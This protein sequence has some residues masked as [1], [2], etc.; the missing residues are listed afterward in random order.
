MW[1]ISEHIDRACARGRSET[2]KRGS[3]LWEAI[4]RACRP[5]GRLMCVPV[6]LGMALAKPAA[7]SFV[8]GYAPVDFTL[9]NV[10]ADGTAA[11]GDGGVSLS[12]TGGNNGSDAPGTTDVTIAALG[13]GTVYFTYAYASPDTPTYDYAGY[14]LAGS[15]VPLADT[16]G[17]SGAVTFQID[18]GQTFGFRVGTADNTGEPGIFT[19]TNF[20]APVPEPGTFPLMILAAC[21]G[22]GVRWRV[23]WATRARRK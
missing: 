14:L 16:D 11:W 3:A 10:N 9:I 18:S 19:V 23:V 22:I 20:S 1:P 21:A 17:N 8:D 15:F 13:S 4:S 6:L 12:L 2:T 7:A 5:C